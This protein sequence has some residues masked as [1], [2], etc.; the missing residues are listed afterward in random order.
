MFSTVCLLGLSTSIGQAPAAPPFVVAKASPRPDI[1][2]WF[3]RDDGWTGGDGA[4]SVRLG[5]DRLLWLF[6]DT[7]IGKVD[8]GRRKDA[9]I[10]NNTIAVQSL[11]DPRPPLRFYWGRDADRPAAFV[12]PADASRW[13]WPQSGALAGD[14]LY[15]F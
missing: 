8:N 9:R 13:Y 5:P 11:R 6:G 15:V 2:Q 7:W 10:V 1:T 4:Y 14:Q 3:R 12:K